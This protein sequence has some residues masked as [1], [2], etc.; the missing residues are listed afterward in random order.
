MK[1]VFADS[2]YYLALLNPDDAAHSR[3]LQV[4]G[5]IEGPVVITAW[6]LTEVADALAAPANRPAF[7]QLL[8]ALREDPEVTT[9][10]RSRSCSRRGQ[11][12]TRAGPTR[13]GL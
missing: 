8:R 10:R 13:S 12:C 2:F 1:T 5:E 3:C 7:L 9:F 11:T 6:V 4:S